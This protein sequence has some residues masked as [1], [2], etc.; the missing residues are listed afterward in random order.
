[1]NIICNTCV[2][3]RIYEQYKL[4]YTNPFIWNAIDTPDFMLLIKNYDNI[5][6]NNFKL[7]YE[8]D[9]Y[10]INIDNL[11]TV[12]YPHY[13]YDKNINIPTIRSDKF[14]THMYSNNIDTYIIDKY[15]ERLLRCNEMPTF[16]LIKGTTFGKNIKCLDDD[17]EYFIN[18]NTKYNKIAYT[19][20]IYDNNIINNTIIVNGKCNINSVDIAKTIINTVKL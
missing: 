9:I 3:G 13:K 10:K 14:G 15:K 20:K 5:N 11:L 7:I 18:I 4:Q 1:M 8:D 16:I 17:I 2:G 12:T 19:D 6:F